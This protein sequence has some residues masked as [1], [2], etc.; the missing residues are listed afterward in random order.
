MYVLCVGLLLVDG[1]GRFVNELGLRNLLT[2]AITAVNC[3]HVF[4][5]LLVCMCSSVFI[6]I[7]HFS[8]LTIWV[9]KCMTPYTRYSSGGQTSGPNFR[10]PAYNVCYSSNIFITFAETD[11]C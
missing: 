7:V 9:I 4:T 6:C 10:G 1:M 8:N 3:F 5:C 11:F 2:K